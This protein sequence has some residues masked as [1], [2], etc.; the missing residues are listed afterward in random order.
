MPRHVSLLVFAFAILVPTHRPLRGQTPSPPSG[1]PP[2]PVREP[3]ACTV[4]KIVDGDTL[5]CQPLGRVRLIGMDTPEAAQKPFGTMA[6]EALAKLVP[7]GTEVL[8]EPDVDARDL[9]DRLLGYVWADGVLVNWAM[10]RQGFAVLLTYPPNV[11]YVDWL[12]A[13]Q[14][15]ARGDSLGLWAVD[16]FACL[17]VEFRRGRC[18][19]GAPRPGRTA[20]AEG[21]VIRIP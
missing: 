5:D 14:T 12:S 19:G 8:L 21:V 2:S 3:K 1:G 11:Q 10:V 17:P 20:P 7:V 15:A 6:T 4:T 13:A 18:K 9:Y 16:G